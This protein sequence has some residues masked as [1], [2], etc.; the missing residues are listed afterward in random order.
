MRSQ[1]LIT[2]A[3]IVLCL[4]MIRCNKS[5][6]LPQNVI[7][8][9][10][11]TNSKVIEGRSIKIAA[12]NSE[13][14]NLKQLLFFVDDNLIATLDGAPYEFMWNTEG[15][16]VGF[17]AIKAEAI[18]INGVKSE[19]GIIIQIVAYVPVTT[20][21]DNRDGNIYQ[22]VEI[23]NQ[24]W[25][26][27]NLRY[28]NEY[29]AA[30]NDDQEL[31]AEYGLVYRTH[32]ASGVGVCPEEWHLPSQV[33]WEKLI[34]N[35]G[36]PDIAGGKLKETGT[37][38]WE[39]P[40]MGASNSSGFSARPAGSLTRDSIPEAFGQSAR[41]FTSFYGNYIFIDHDSEA[42][43]NQFLHPANQHYSIRCIRDY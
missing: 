18:D 30:P 9:Y 1:T 41:F 20:L 29:S 34:Q 25:M 42:V 37:E 43:K 6:S 19:A 35:L 23:G 31:V 36:G 10:P 3:Y 21:T 8:L 39:Y 11:K 33:D 28:K 15:F 40:N 4:F 24:V 14:D 32:I 5:E 2:L 16:D 22:L 17:H 38:R 27:E 7:T 12:H 26:K 13:S